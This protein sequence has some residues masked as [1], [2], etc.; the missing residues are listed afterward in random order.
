MADEGRVVRDGATV[1]R[2]AGF[3]TPAVHA[4]LNHL[5]DAGFKHAPRVVGMDGEFE[6]VTFVEGETPTKGE[7]RWIDEP[8]LTSVGALLRRYHDAVRTFV[9]PEWA[10][11]QHTS[12]PTTG[13]LVGH[14]DLYL[15]NVV[16]RDRDA[17]GLIDFDFAHPADPLWDLAMAAWH[18][19]PLLTRPRPAPASE[20]PARLR[21]LLEAYGVAR[22]QRPEV[23]DIVTDL[24]GRMRRRHPAESQYDAA[25]HD[26]ERNRDRWLA[27]VR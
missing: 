19:L 1:R 7:E 9:P 20:L 22:A 27:A 8:V 10:R 4:L 15:G 13:T 5:Q 6:I 2:P 18:W 25:L 17:I 14:N 3:W 16:F 26:L 24:G 12:I 23:V 21:V 11:W